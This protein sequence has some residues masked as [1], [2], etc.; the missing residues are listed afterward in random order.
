MDVLPK[1]HALPITNRLA[2]QQL[3]LTFKKLAFGKIQPVDLFNA[4]IIIQL[5]PISPVIVI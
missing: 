3:Q 4:L 5:P 2:Q 1:G